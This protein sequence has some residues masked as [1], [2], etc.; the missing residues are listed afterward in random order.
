MPG[1][2]AHGVNREYQLQARDILIRKASP[3]EL[4]PFSGDG[5][6]VGVMLGSAQRTFDVLLRGDE[7]LVAAE[8]KRT[9]DR[10]QLGELDQFA[11]RVEL[12][13][14]ELQ[15]DV[16]GVFFAKTGYQAGAVRT[17]PDSGIE[18][19]VCA[20]NQ[21]NAVFALQYWRYDSERERRIVDGVVLINRSV[22]MSASL[23]A[24]VVRVDGSRDDLGKIG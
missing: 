20:E 21:V 23:G 17:G 11:H 24:V 6:D 16:A 18:T 22:S 10:V 14:K 1:G 12:L 3:K 13:R 9:A 4:L 7:G 15:I 19:T 8:C 5:V 2:Q